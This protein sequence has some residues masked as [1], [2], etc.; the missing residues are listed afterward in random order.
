MERGTQ[1]IYV[2]AHADGDTNHPDCESGFI[3]SVTKIYIF[4]RFWRKPELKELRTKANSEAVKAE[5]LIEQD[6]VPA[7]QVA[8]AI[9]W[10][11]K[12]RE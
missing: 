10:I 7:E 6:S 1:I 8:A 9:D 5:D 12:E 2:P 4:C 11:D 3:S